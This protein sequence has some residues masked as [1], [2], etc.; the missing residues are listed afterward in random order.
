MNAIRLSWKWQLI[1]VMV[2]MGALVLGSFILVASQSVRISGLNKL[3]A[4]LMA[5][6]VSDGR[7]FIGQMR[8]RDGPHPPLPPPP[9]VQQESESADAFAFHDPDTGRVSSS[10]NWPEDLEI[11]AL[12]ERVHELYTANELEYPSRPITNGPHARPGRN[13]NPMLPHPP[14]SEP[15]LRLDPVVIDTVRANG[16]MWRLLGFS[17]GRQVFLGVRSMDGFQA[18]MAAFWRAVGLALP[19]SLLLIGLTAWVLARRALSPVQRLSEAASRITAIDLKARLET[20]DEPPEFDELITV[21]NAMLDRLEASFTQARRFSADAAHELN[22]PLTVL[23]G[24]L[25]SLLQSE[26]SP[27]R[28]AD[29]T[30]V[31]EQTQHLKEIINKLHL[32]SQADAGCLPVDFQE[33]DFSTLVAEVLA[34]GKAMAP[35]LSFESTGED[36]LGLKGDPG[37]LRQLVYNLVSNAIKYNRPKGMVRTRLYQ[38]ADRVCFEITNSG[39]AIPSRDASRIFERFFRMDPSRNTAIPGRGLGLSLAQEFARAH[40]GHLELVANADE[41]ITFRLELPV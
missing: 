37:L 7:P 32:L 22:T 4:E 38:E 33:L 26:P 15:P 13:W 11:P 30:T 31:L 14:G 8:P 6:A 21:Y 19:V 25:D 40:G 29:L 10:G 36:A 27:E 39:M 12:A 2:A 23:R 18:S 35:D 1:L 28:Q 24:N 5:A 3:D 16:Q 17:T 34:D 41:A 20:R 9:P